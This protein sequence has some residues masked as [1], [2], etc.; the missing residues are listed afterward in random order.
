MYPNFQYLNFEGNRCV[1]V[2]SL[3]CVTLWKYSF[4]FIYLFMHQKIQILQLIKFTAFSVT[5]NNPISFD[6]PSQS[7]HIKDT[8]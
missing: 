1:G 3:L 6:K 2:K 8:L 5:V 4:A 7:E